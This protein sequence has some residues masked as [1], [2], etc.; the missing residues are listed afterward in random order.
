MWSVRPARWVIKVTSSIS[1]IKTEVFNHSSNTAKEI[2]PSRL[3]FG[4]VLKQSCHGTRCSRSYVQ[5]TAGQ[6]LGRPTGYLL[7]E[8]D[9][10]CTAFSGPR[11]PKFY[12]R[13]RKSGDNLP[14]TMNE[15]CVL[16]WRSGVT[17]EDFLDC[18]HHLRTVWAGPAECL[19]PTKCPVKWLYLYCVHNQL[20]KMVKTAHLWPRVFPFQ[21]LLG[22]DLCILQKCGDSVPWC[23][24]QKKYT[25]TFQ[26]VL[27]IRNW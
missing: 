14:V 10:R 9:G 7:L 1:W 21:D 6:P 8:L 3:L 2:K 23:R 20:V 13:H 4:S 11:S 24:L 12:K 19:K 22:K 16:L 25:L 18:L 26:T 17:F 15:G 27:T 5:S